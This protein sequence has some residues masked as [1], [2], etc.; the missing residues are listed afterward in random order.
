MSVDSIDFFIHEGHQPP[1]LAKAQ[2][3]ELLETVLRR[4]GVALDNDIHLFVSNAADEVDEAGEEPEPL[5]VG[6][7]VDD[8]G[9]KRHSH[10]HCQRCR[11]VQVSVNY[12]SRTEQRMFSPNAQIRRIRRWAQKSFGL[13]GPAAGDFVLQP[14]GSDI[15]AGLQRGL[16]E[17][18]RD[19]TCSACF[20]FSKEVTPQG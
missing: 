10:V 15:D 3:E 9:I 13:I 5:P 16:A 2:G 7:T 6:L 11:W 8:A 1:R 14:C 12:Q 18:V 17:F 19:D 20:D 4:N